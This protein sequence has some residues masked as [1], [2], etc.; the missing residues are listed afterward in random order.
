MPNLKQLIE[1]ASYA[2]THILATYE[3]A[4][5]QISL[6]RNLN[7]DHSKIILDTL[8][9][10]S[11]TIELAQSHLEQAYRTDHLATL[12]SSSINAAVESIR[13]AYDNAICSLAAG[14]ALSTRQEIDLMVKLAPVSDAILTA[15]R[16]SD[17]VV[18]SLC[19]YRSQHY[20]GR[21]LD[22]RGAA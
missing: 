1:D 14:S 8:E 13:L 15:Q 22:N 3:K 10:I 7:L 4:T 11:T 19:E 18:Q 9:P 5:V 17:V 2:V 12:D 16:R 6:C 21:E 20:I